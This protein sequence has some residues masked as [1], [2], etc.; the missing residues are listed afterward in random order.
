[1]TTVSS[2]T[3][4]GAITAESPL[5][6]VDKDFVQAA[7]TASSTQTDAGK[8][9]HR[10]TSNADVRSFARHMIA[11]NMRL[12]VQLKAVA[13]HGVQ[14]PKDNSDLGLL[15]SLKPLTGADFDRE[16]ARKLGLEANRQAIAAYE[17]EAGDGETP[18]LRQAAQN[19]LPTL[20]E[21]YPMG[22][23]LAQRLGVS[24]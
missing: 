21:H 15:D 8:T 13:R 5:P 12:T 24:E 2:D 11:D 3:G 14:V 16:Y 19:A 1:M 4:S 7:T 17:K 6:A 10:N 23:K 22:Q 20:R 18:A 9:A